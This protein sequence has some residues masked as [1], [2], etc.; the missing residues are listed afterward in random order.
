M[1]KSYPPKLITRRKNTTTPVSDP[2]FEQ[3]VQE[4]GELSDET[5]SRISFAMPWQFDDD[6]GYRQDPD[7]FPTKAS[8]FPKDKAQTQQRREELQVECFTKFHENPQ[9]NTS[10]RGLVGRLTGWGYETSSFIWEIQQVLEEISLDYRNRLYNFMPKYVGRAFIEGEL[11]LILT[12]HESGFVE[13]DFIDPSNFDESRGSDQSG[14]LFHPTGIIFH[15]NKTMMPLAYAIKSPST[16]VT[17]VIPSIFLARFP[18]LKKVLFEHRDYQPNEMQGSMSRKG[19]FKPIGGFYRFVLSWDRSFV[20]RRNI[21]YLRTTLQWLNH[22][23]NLKKYEIDHKKSA[24]AY[25][26]VITIETPRHFRYWLALSDEEKKK[27][28]ILAKKTPGG[29]L[30]L[31]PGMKL[32]VK[33]PQL[34]NISDTDTDILQMATSGLGEPA[35]VTTGSAKGTFASVKMSRGPWSDRTSDEI[36]YFDRFQKYDFWSSIFFLRSAVSDFPK[37]FK[38]NMAVG[39]GDNGDPIFKK[40]DR[41]PEQL[42]EIAY[43]I[44]EAVDFEKKVKGLLGVKHASLHDILG[45][46]HSSIANII[47]FGNWKTLMLRK[48]TEKKNFPKVMSSMEIEME[49][50]QE[51]AIEGKTQKNKEKTGETK[52]KEKK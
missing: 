48:E 5:L 46:P 52:E 32:E 29:T 25:L 35:D 17:E 15:P 28:G 23:E 33:N 9:I 36:A 12:L 49:S 44:S 18:E 19:V 24:G 26:W 2:L 47:G 39:F 10:V 1:A 50:A 37:T 43:P 34:P 16:Q 14:F 4:L 21:S 45:I 11:Y 6:S 20:T 30:I 31:P 22:Y 13:I 42:I 51:K 3:A 40:V 8:P 41:K 38:I 7:D 27:T